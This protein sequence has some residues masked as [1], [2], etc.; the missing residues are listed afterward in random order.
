MTQESLHTKRNSYLAAIVIPGVLI[1][2]LAYINFRF[3]FGIEVTPPMLIIPFFVGASFGGFFHHIRLLRAREARMVVQLKEVQAELADHANQLNKALMQE[4][5]VSRV[6][7]LFVSSLSHELRTPLNAILGLSEALQEEV[8]GPLSKMQRESLETI[9]GSGR[10]LLSLIVDILEFSKIGAGRLTTAITECEPNY[11]AE[12]IIKQNQKNATEKKLNLEFS[13][14]SETIHFQTDPGKCQKILN[15]LLANAAKFTP[16][17]GKIGL[18]VS[19]DATG[20][21]IR[22]CIWDKGIGIEGDKLDLLAKPFVQ[23]DSSLSRKHGGMGMGL[24]LST[25][26]SHLI[27]ATLEVESQFGEGSR[28]TLS[29]PIN[30][31]ACIKLYG[32]LNCPF[33]YVL[34]EWLDQAQLSHLVEWH[35][36]EHMASKTGPTEGDKQ[37]LNKLADEINRVKERAAETH[38]TLNQPPYRPSS[39]LGL[40]TLLHAERNCPELAGKLRRRIFRALWKDSLDI[41]QPEILK[42]LMKDM[43]IDDYTNLDELQAEVA[44]RTNTW[45]ELNYDLIPT[46]VSVRTNAVYMGLGQRSLLFDFLQAEIGTPASSPNNPDVR[47]LTGHLTNEYL[48]ARLSL[49]HMIQMD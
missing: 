34:N 42:T 43:D 10:H 41:S 12:I 9:E 22:F 30:G 15:K 36:V 28:F 24:A 27:G 45:K 31:P 1:Q 25:R 6:K 47:V 11:L 26:L 2:I 46:A 3:L 7:E 14:L 39:N 23:A 29:V 5:S 16:E 49:E 4:Q 19:L 21:N 44:A 8:Y 35:G 38:V 40:V 32:D 18:S 20:N 37:A 17:G 33:S 48:Q 13:P